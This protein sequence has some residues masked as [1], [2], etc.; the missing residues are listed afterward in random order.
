MKIDKLRLAK[1]QRA[2]N[3]IIFGTTAGLLTYAFF[4]HFHIAI[5]GWNLGLLFAPLVAGYVETI[6]AQKL[7]GEDIGAISAFIL[8]LVTVIYGFIINNPTLG[9][10]IITAG[11]IAIII[12]A[13]IPT[14]ANYFGIVVI[15][16]TL[17]YLTGFFKKIANFLYYKLK[18]RVGK[19]EEDTIDV[20]ALFNEK[21]SNERLN[22]QN[23]FY[24]TSTDVLDN[25][26]LN[27]GY[28]SATTVFDRNT[29]LITSS[30]KTL[31]IKKLNALKE[32][33]DECLIKLADEIKKENGNG[34]VNL[35]IDYFLNGIG[36]S[37]FQIV[38]RGI[39]VKI[40]V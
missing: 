23:F 18:K 29:H 16:S 11:S 3:C 6:F 31:E 37:N 33:K 12:Q 15:V 21:E 13:A 17:S 39:G 26:Y 1:L 36:G 10:N 5:L 22:S 40:K 8:F 32:R 2:F 38:A 7:I 24:I 25:E 4:L 20:I 34:V 28:F 9:Y 14:F 19:P 30:P 27:L 35:E